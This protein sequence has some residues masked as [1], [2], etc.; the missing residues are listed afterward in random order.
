MVVK[1][2]LFYIPKLINPIKC[3]KS[4][5]NVTFTEEDI[6][7]VIQKLDSNKA[8]GHGKINIRMLTIGGKS[9]IMPV[10][11]IYKQCLKKGCL[12]DECKQI[13]LMGMV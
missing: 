3:D 11:I 5:S 1:F 9:M 8:H 2:P 7:K 12:S 4:L 13:K 6:Q 10:Q